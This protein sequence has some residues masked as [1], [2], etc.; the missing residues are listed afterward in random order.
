MDRVARV[1]AFAAPLAQAEGVELLDVVLAWEGRQQVLRL[2][3]ERPDSPT[4]VADCEAVSRSVEAALDAQDLIPHHYVLEVASA[5]LTRPLHGLADLQ[6]HIGRLVR[7][8]PRAGGSPVWG[9]LRGA[10]DAALTVE[11]DRA[12]P[13]RIP[14]ADVASVNREVAFGPRPGAPGRRP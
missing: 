1:R 11:P 2:T 5:G 4:S 3:I 13:V 6:R 12:A 7:V 8:V 10:D 9:T 14:L